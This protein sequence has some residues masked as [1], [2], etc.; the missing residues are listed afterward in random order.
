ML[1]GLKATFFIYKK[2]NLANKPQIL[3]LK[4]EYKKRKVL[5]TW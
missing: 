2:R 5:R 4:L 3:W 1:C